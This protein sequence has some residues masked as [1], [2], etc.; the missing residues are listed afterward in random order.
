MFA[1]R[2]LETSDLKDGKTFAK[3]EEWNSEVSEF[4]LKWASFHTKSVTKLTV[5]YNVIKTF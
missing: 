1:G 5:R 4:G 3:A 2:V